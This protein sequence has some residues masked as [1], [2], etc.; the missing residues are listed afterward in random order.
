MKHRA[1]CILLGL[2]FFAFG[3]ERVKSQVEIIGD[4]DVQSMLRMRRAATDTID[5]TG[6]RIQLFFGNNRGDAQKIQSEFSYQYPEWSNETY[7]LYYDPNWRF[8]VGNFYHKIDAQPMMQ[9]L[10]RDFANVFLIRDKIE[11]PALR[12]KL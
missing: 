11:L 8:R 4:D 5:L 12:E 6:Y 1:L 10:Q 3:T 9:E 2:I 7:L